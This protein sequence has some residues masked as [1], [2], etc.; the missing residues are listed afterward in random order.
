MLMVEKTMFQMR[1]DI[2]EQEN[3]MGVLP[4]NGLLISMSLPMIM[5]ML[6]QALYNIVDSIFVSQIE[7]YAF[8]AVS[9]AFPVQ[10]LMIAV[11][12]GTSVGMSAF[13]SRSLGE[14]EFDKANQ[15]ANNGIFL[16]LISCLIFVVIGLSLSG[17]FYAS[18]TKI[19][20]VR[21]YGTTYLT[22][23]TT[24]SVG[25]FMQVTFERLLQSTGKTIFT[26][27]TQGLG[28]LINIIL[29]P[30]LIFGWFGLPKM[31]VAGA[32]IATV[33]GQL[34]AASLAIW[35]HV[36]F[37]GEIKISFK[38]FKPNKALIG[39]IYKVGAPS[40]VMQA[41][42]SV[43]VY[44]MNLILEAFTVAQTVFGAYFKLQSFIFMPVFGLNNG[45]VPIIAYNYGAGKKGR[46]LKTM[47]TSVAY[48]V[49]IM[50][51]GLMIMEVF[52]A[53]LLGLFEATPEILEMGVPALRIIC[54][55]FVFA[56]F[57][58]VTGSVFQALGNGVYSMLVSIARQLFVLLPV[59]YLFSLSGNVNL[60]W[61]A[62]PI[63]ELASVAMTTFFLRKINRDI[64]SH[65][66][67]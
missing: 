55:S 34:A 13:I 58:I 6:V 63:A 24:L 41:I 40:I 48:G 17:V 1:G 61:W 67:E 33:V 25:I 43:M 35:F 15:T 53:Q 51:V 16:E 26:M 19:P 21:Q 44:G 28:A 7:E 20:E 46:V 37:N 65:I 56:G 5:S 59:A 30:I 39:Q 31:G 36:S 4:I 57:C 49:G 66:G 14:K 47:K 2:M 9:L 11:S 29:D 27:Y 38:G 10:S 64:I 45:M 8:R 32:A 52:P 3:K 62:F 50:L 18:Q 12:V 42:G 23:V 60:I 54:L 22:L